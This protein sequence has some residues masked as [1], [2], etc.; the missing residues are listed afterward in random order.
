MMSTPGI[1]RVESGCVRFGGGGHVGGLVGHNLDA[2]L[3]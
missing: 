3:S 1:C 2:M